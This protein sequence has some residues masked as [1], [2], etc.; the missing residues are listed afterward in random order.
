M[1]AARAGNYKHSARGLIDADHHV[2]N[3]AAKHSFSVPFSTLTPPLARRQQRGSRHFGER[4]PPPPPVFDM[5]GAVWCHDH[6]SF[7][8]SLWSGDMAVWLASS[9]LGVENSAAACTTDWPNF[10]LILTF[11]K[12]PMRLGCMSLTM[13]LTP[14]RQMLIAMLGA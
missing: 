4:P 11:V 3:A 9:S 14:L 7:R 1:V 5:T 2:M 8:H 12:L 13:C 6:E 10:S